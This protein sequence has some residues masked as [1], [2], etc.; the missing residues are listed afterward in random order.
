MLGMLLCCGVAIAA[1]AT[2]PTT[3]TLRSAGFLLPEPMALQPFTLVDDQGKAFT[4]KSFADRWTLLFFGY[5]HCPDVCPATLAQ[6]R[7][8][9]TAL[10]TMDPAADVSVVFVSIDPKRDGSE[11]L[12]RYTKMFGSDFLGVGG[13]QADVDAFARQFRVK[14][15]VS[16][17]TSEAYLIDHTSSVALISP[18]AQLRALFS[19]PLRTEAVAMDIKQ[20][21]RAGTPAGGT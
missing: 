7:A 20:L 12:A 16:S 15:A 21:L 18:R 13:D 1:P 8:V 9:K 6:I 3:A 19:V 10:E 5:T 2:P 4:A 17:G 14:Y 11:E